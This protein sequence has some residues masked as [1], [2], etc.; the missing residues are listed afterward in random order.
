MDEAAEGRPSA[1]PQEDMEELPIAVEE[2]G[3]EER[4]AEAAEGQE[5]RAVR[6]PVA[7]VA[8]Q[9]GPHA[10]PLFGGPLESPVLLP[11]G[12]VS[13]DCA[14]CALQRLAASTTHICTSAR[15]QL[16][17]V[18]PSPSTSLMSYPLPLFA[19]G[20]AGARMPFYPAYDKHG[21]PIF[22]PYNYPQ[23]FIAP[24]RN[25]QARKRGCGCWQEGLNPAPAGRCKLPA[26]WAAQIPPADSR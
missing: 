11:M 19:G 26:A 12:P 20:A 4:E 3:T 1:P 13:V 24:S 7:P 18:E 6:P 25:R 8:Q 14:A 9:R 17:Q 21:A 22:M 15:A 23:N 2:G 5:P 16:Q 10:Q